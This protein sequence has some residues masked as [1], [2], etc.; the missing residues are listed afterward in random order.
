M[1]ELHVRGLNGKRA[2]VRQ[3]IVAAYPNV[4]N[5]DWEKLFKA[6]PAILGNIIADLLRHK[7]GKAAKHGKPGPITRATAEEIYDFYRNA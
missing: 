3:D 4:D 7:N 6:D 1:T 2:K 5:I